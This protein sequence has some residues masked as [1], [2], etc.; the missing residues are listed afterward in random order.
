MK[1]LLLLP[2]VAIVAGGLAAY[3][4]WA[5]QPPPESA[6]AVVSGRVVDV[7]RIVQTRWGRRQLIPRKVYVGH[8]LAVLRED[9]EVVTLRIP[10]WGGVPEARIEAMS[11]VNIRGRYDP[12]ENILY[13]LAAGKNV[14]STYYSS[15]EAQRE[16]SRWNLLVGGA[17]AFASIVILGLLVSNRS[18]PDPKLDA[19][20]S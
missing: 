16:N 5:G 13:E 12:R 1:K 11:Q 20:Q 19:A 14:L 7:E 6:L 18:K 9:D 15:S 17:M 2:L 4:G 8:D 10:D 3:S